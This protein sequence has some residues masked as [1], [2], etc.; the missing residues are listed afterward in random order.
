LSN[1]IA[2]H[3]HVTILGISNV[4]VPMAEPATKV[5]GRI[6]RRLSQRR[7]VHSG[8]HMRMMVKKRSGVTEPLSFDKISMRISKL[9][10]NL[11]VE[12]DAIEITRAVIA[13]LYD[14][15]TTSEIDHEAARVAAATREPRPVRFASGTGATCTGP[16]KS[17]RIF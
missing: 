15:I 6:V 10:Y 14:G 2:L 9:C 5:G 11:S 13:G 3:W 4:V 8:E 16:G 7:D 1:F 12:V 17:H